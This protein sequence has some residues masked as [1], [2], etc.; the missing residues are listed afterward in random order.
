[1]I[2]LDRRGSG[3]PLVL[4]HG[5]GSRWQVFEPIID[6]LAEDHEV[7]AIDL[8]GFGGSPADPAVSA[9]P[10]GYAERLVVLF[11]ELGIERP[12]VVGNSLGGGIALEL[13]RQGV[14]CR[15]TAFSPIGFWRMPG[16]IWCQCVLTS[17]RTTG[18]VA[19]PLVETLAANKATRAMLLGAF[20]GHPIRVSP[21]RAIADARG[22]VGSTMFQAARHGFTG[23]T[24]GGSP[25]ALTQLPVTIAWGTRDILLTHRTQSARARAALPLARHVDLPGCGHL[26]FHDDPGLCADVILHG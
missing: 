17:L 9:A 11:D 22:L 24:L 5:I 23:Y 21:E 25:G 7:L 8:P 16:R 3:D 15:V 19:A 26:P 13:G 6:R 10:R 1:M 12:H 4:I 20:Y 18:R 2:N 14:A